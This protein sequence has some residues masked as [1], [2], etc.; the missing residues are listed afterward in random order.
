MEENSNGRSDGGLQ[1][2]TNDMLIIFI[3]FVFLTVMLFCMFYRLG[4]ENGY[5]SGVLAATSDQD[6]LTELG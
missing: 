4:Y 5:A 2:I 3:V 1:M 6:T